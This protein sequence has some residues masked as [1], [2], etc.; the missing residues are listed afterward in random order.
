MLVAL[1]F[2]SSEGQT[3]K[4][5]RVVATKL[6]ALGLDTLIYDLDVDDPSLRNIDACV[7]AGSLH[8]GHHQ[9]KLKTFAIKNQ[10]SL[11]DMP[12]LF[13]SV[14]LAAGSDEKHDLDGAQKKAQEFLGETGLITGHVRTVAGAVYDKRLGLL[15]RLLLHYI[16]RRQNVTL[17]PSGN[18]EFTDWKKL[19]EYVEKFTLSELKVRK[20]K[21]HECAVQY[22]KTSF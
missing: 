18:T 16:L 14:S 20:K 1:V 5:S 19:E 4:I 8:Y 22:Q 17:N 2:A 12:L 7:L 15:E 9:K 11:N 10:K 6:E 13:L 3:D 21:I